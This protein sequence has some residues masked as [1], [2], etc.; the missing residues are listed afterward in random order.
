[1]AGQHLPMHNSMSPSCHSQP[2]PSS[3]FRSSAQSSAAH[4][5]TQSTVVSKINTPCT[6]GLR[7]ACTACFLH[8]SRRRIGQI[9][10]PSVLATFPKRTLRL[11]LICGQGIPLKAPRQRLNCD[12]S[13]NPFCSVKCS[14]WCTW[15]YPGLTF[16]NRPWTPLDSPTP[17]IRKSA[18]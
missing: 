14:L 13:V 2:P 16:L 6:A 18:V 3:T 7:A 9:G 8:R 15:G 12:R 4:I 11:G 1:M 17:E 10:V 5:V